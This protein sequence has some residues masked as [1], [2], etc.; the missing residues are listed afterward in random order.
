MWSKLDRENE[1]EIFIEKSKENK[2]EEVADYNEQAL[3]E[4]I[5][6][7]TNYFGYIHI[8]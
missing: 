3:N 6:D 7:L 8:G 2:Q 1:F 4:D 5:E